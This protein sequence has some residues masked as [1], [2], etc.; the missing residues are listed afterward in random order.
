MGARRFAELLRRYGTEA[1][2]G[3]IAA[4]MDHT[5][6]VAREHVRSIPDGVY[7]AESYMDDDGV[8]AGRRIPIRVKVT[9]KGDEME[10]DLSDVGEQ[11]RGF[12]NSGEAAGR[13]WE[14]IALICSR[15]S[16]MGLSP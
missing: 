4:I 16:L 14:K 15:S 6:A 12:Y 13:A 1:V 10:I 5:E 3:G 9:V 8:A 7:E 11:V 2:L